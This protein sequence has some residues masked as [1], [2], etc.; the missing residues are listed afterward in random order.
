MV[1]E[2]A[3]NMGRL[4]ATNAFSMPSSD[5]QL[6]DL[7]ASEYVRLPP[8]IR[9]LEPDLPEALIV[10]RIALLQARGWRCLGAFNAQGSLLGVAGYSVLSHLF[11]G[12]VLYVENV[13]LLPAARGGGLGRQLM[14]WLKNH[15]M[16][17]GCRKITLDAYQK[18]AAA[19]AFY[20]RL[21]YDPR[22]VHFVLDL[23]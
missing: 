22:G 7:T 19:Q 16:A 11:S 8:L 20:Q 12:P 5:V 4:S 14:A 10:E 23:D 9:L 6:R 17:S 1:R 21:G 2:L 3:E 13:V 15:A 18:N